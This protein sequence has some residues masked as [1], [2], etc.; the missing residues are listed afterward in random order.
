MF[1]KPQ[2]IFLKIYI[3]LLLADLYFSELL[4]LF[5]FS[6]LEIKKKK[7]FFFPHLQSHKVNCTLCT[8]C[9]IPEIT[10]ADAATT[11]VAHS[12]TPAVQCLIKDD[13][14]LGNIF[15]VKP[16]FNEKT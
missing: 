1:Q 11:L 4:L 3:E 10:S 8:L 13:G 7:K 2:T 12:V 9:R 6:V 14:G 16:E 5:V 15:Q